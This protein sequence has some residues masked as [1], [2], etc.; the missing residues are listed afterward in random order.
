MQNQVEESSDQSE[1]VF[2]LDEFFDRASIRFIG[3][4]S[5]SSSSINLLK[6]ILGSGINAKY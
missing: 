1:G 6:T 2:E 3:G 5:F 4:A